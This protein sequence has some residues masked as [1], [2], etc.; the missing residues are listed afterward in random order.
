MNAYPIDVSNS[1]AILLGND[2]CCDGFHRDYKARIQTH[3]HSDHLEEFETSKGYQDIYLTE[4]A[5]ELLC[6]EFDADLPYRDNIIAKPTRA[7]WQVNGNRVE[8]FPNE[9]MLGSV[10]VCVTLGD[11]RRI[12]YSGDFQ[13]PIEEPMEVEALVVDSTYGS[14]ESCRQYSQ[15]EAE[16]R[17]L[18]LVLAKIRNGPVH[19]KAFRGTLQRGLQVLCG[20]VDVPFVGTDRFCKEVGVYRQYGFAIGPVLSI[21]SAEG[22]Q[23]LKAGKYVRVYGK[24]DQL[25]ADPPPTGTTITLSAYMSNPSDPVLEYTPRSYRVAMSNHADFGGTLEYVRAT[26]ARYVVTD[27]SRSGHALELALAIRERLGVAAVPSRSPTTLEWGM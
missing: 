26:G 17:L 9:H 12:G 15:G 16:A 6:A 1:G 24:G 7:P 5:R 25:S 23:A 14:P 13:W 27:S 4:A 3:I 19:V 18:E 2:I 20:S 11:G 8:L 22:K 21:G 10:Q